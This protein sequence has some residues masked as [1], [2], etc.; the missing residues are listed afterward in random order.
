MWSG[1]IVFA[2]HR[3]ASDTLTHREMMSCGMELLRADDLR[4]PGNVMEFAYV[5]VAMDL[6][7]YMYMGRGFGGVWGVFFWGGGGGGGGD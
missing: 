4:I 3:Q 6:G 7:V 2:K 1:C 5:M